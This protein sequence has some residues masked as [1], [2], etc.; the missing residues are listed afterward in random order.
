MFRLLNK[1]AIWH[2]CQCVNNWLWNSSKLPFI[3][4]V[5]QSTSRCNTRVPWADHRGRASRPQAMVGPGYAGGWSVGQSVV[6]NF[7]RYSGAQVH[8][9]GRRAFQAV[10]SAYMHHLCEHISL[11]HLTTSTKYTCGLPIGINVLPDFWHIILACGLS[12][13][14]A[15]SRDFTIH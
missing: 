4:A 7:P 9:P 5:L 2:L 13:S 3:G 8:S 14:A 1:S 10:G 6:S 11:T 12:T 15:Y